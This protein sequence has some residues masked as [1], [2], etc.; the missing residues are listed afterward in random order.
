MS[1][2]LILPG[3]PNYRSPN[4]TGE[5]SHL[6]QE[7]LRRI[8]SNWQLTPATFAHKISR[9]A[10]IP[11]QHLRYISLRIAKAVA[12][13]NA[14]II[15]SMPPRHGKSQLVSIYTP[16]W[17]LEYIGKLNIILASYGADLAEGF[18]RQIRAIIKDPANEGLLKVRIGTLAKAEEFNTNLGGYMYAVGL[19]G[20][21]T[22]RGAHVLLIDDYIK[23]IKEAL[24]PAYRDYIWNWYVTTA[25]TRLEPN[26]SV[27]IVAT[28]WHSDDLIGRLLQHERD[29]WEYIEIPA[30]ALEDDLIGRQP[31]EALFPERYDIAALMKLKRSLGTVFFE[32]LF[33][34]RPVDETMRIT[35]TSWIQIWPREKMLPRHMKKCRIWDLAATEGAGDY[36]T[37][38]KCSYD[39][40]SDRFFIEHVFRDQ[41]GPGK[42]EAKVLEI[43]ERDGYDC[44]IGIEQEPGSAGKI[45]FEHFK[46]QVLK[47][48]RVTSISTGGKSKVIR[49]QPFLAAAEDQQVY[50][51][52]D[53][54]WNK[55]FLDEFETFPSSNKAIHDDMIDTA[56]EAYTH[57]TGKKNL[58]V[59]WGR[60]ST[61]STGP[62]TTRRSGTRNSNTIQSANSEAATPRRVKGVTWGR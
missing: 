27:I 12:K 33:Q 17:L 20:A 29:N 52:E 54:E 61:D 2:G 18:S 9:G 49:A 30:I 13:G 47:E 55:P 6:D 39:P 38:T 57:L 36:L 42:V 5:M 56:G 16:A 43:A 35:D 25:L 48:Y 7:Q 32:A 34:Q 50:L 14:R 28:R 37:G 21:I 46:E 4:I 10:W 51:L 26:G 53:P 24:S 3:D 11:S 44:D 1:S 15:L 31:G 23:E 41:L 59:S 40:A 58:S 62:S 22:G 60:S 45:L 19:G 8:M